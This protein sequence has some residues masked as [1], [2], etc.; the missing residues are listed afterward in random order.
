MVHCAPPHVVAPGPLKGRSYNAR[1]IGHPLQIGPVR[2]DTNLLLAPIAR[3]C[4]LAFRITCREASVLD[5]VHGGVGLACTDL[6]S[7]QGLLRGTAQSLDLAQTN[8]LDKPV[9]MQ[10]YGSD[11]GIMA[12]GAAWAAEHGATVVDINMGCPVDKVTK[13]D[14]GSKLMCD[15]EKAVRIAGACREAL[16]EH[17]PLTCKMRLGWSC[18]DDAPTLAC[19]LVDVGVAAITVHGRTTDQKFKGLADRAKIR[20]VVEAV[21]AKTA[22]WP[23]GPVPVIGNG[24]VTDTASCLAMLRVTGCAGVMIGRGALSHPWVFR[25]CWAA[26]LRERAR[27]DGRPPL[28]IPAQPSDAQ[29]IAIIR[30]FFE[31][32]REYHGDHYAMHQIRSRISWMARPLQRQGEPSVKPFKEAVRTAAEPRAVHDALDVFLAG[33]LRGEGDRENAEDCADDAERKR[34]VGSCAAIAAHVMP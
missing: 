9:G 5:W 25:D 2:L 21:R 18:P 27:S 13:K 24:D 15:M 30:R 8:D 26:Q 10:L 4:D 7:P 17:I 12:A 23:G 19:R 1:L 32:M 22:R 28:E 34:D 31:L 6:L 20:Q 16:P 29:V 14:G 11:E 3:Y 33:G